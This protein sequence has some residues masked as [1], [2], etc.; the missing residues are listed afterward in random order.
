MR[1]RGASTGTAVDTVSRSLPMAPAGLGSHAECSVQSRSSSR[2]RAAVHPPPCNLHYYGSLDL[3]GGRIMAKK[4]AVEA[5]VSG[6]DQQVGFRAL[7]MKQ[8]IEYNLAGSARNDANQVVRFTLQGSKKRIDWAVATIHER[9][10]KDRLT[11]KS[12]R[13]LQKSTPRGRRLRSWTGLRR[14]KTSRTNII[15]SSS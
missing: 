12:R 5:T 3:A 4:E 9:G 14:G 2:M 1:F 13:P 11:S 10:P 8:A 7:V 6:N 15:S